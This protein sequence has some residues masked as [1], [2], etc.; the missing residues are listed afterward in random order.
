MFTSTSCGSTRPELATSEK[1]PPHKR[2]RK[3]D[4][5]DVSCLVAT[6][7]KPVFLSP[8][9]PTK[10]TQSPHFKSPISKKALDKVQVDNFS[11]ELIEEDITI[12]SSLPHYLDH[13]FGCIGSSQS[14]ITNSRIPPT[15]NCYPTTDTPATE[16]GCCESLPVIQESQGFT[17]THASNEL[18]TT[19][20]RDGD[21]LCSVEKN[22]TRANVELS[23]LLFPSSPPELHLNH[24]SCDTLT[25]SETL[26]RSSLSNKMTHTLKCTSISTPHDKKHMLYTV[27][28]SS[29]A[30]SQ[31]TSGKCAKS[32]RRRSLSSSKSKLKY[33]C[34]PLCVSLMECAR[35]KPES[36]VSILAIVLQGT[37]TISSNTSI[38]AQSTNEQI[39][40][41]I[42]YALYPML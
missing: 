24:S 16:D 27:P 30:M 17:V 37:A 33:T 14:L 3:L 22:E 41:M 26:S 10:Q 21:E 42:A 39:T 15:P 23:P 12:Q 5:A 25:R 20:S 4:I 2:R 9:K 8:E 32:T 35:M 11:Q 34:P 28:Q 29:V 36:I 19:I 1:S 6:K 38:Q 18:P 40:C 31:E 7:Q 13:V